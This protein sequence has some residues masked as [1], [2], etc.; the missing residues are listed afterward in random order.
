MSNKFN[1]IEKLQ[2]LKSINNN[3]NYLKSIKDKENKIL[4]Y[5]KKISNNDIIKPTQKII[6]RTKKQMLDKDKYLDKTNGGEIN[7]KNMNN[8]DLN[9]QVL[10]NTYL[11]ESKKKLTLKQNNYVVMD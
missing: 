10:N 4:K 6:K 7:E 5:Y 1:K 3:Y 8:Q 2:N 9:N 11:E